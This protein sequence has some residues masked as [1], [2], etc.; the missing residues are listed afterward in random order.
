MNPF[1][2][3]KIIFF[4]YFIMGITTLVFET[5]AIRELTIVFGGTVYSIST[6]LGAFMA[7]SAIGAFYF[8]RIA[9][10]HQKPL[11]LYMFL[12]GGLTV[13]IPLFPLI[14]KITY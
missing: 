13:F 1:M 9:D 2:S 4:L 5:L 10:H 8:G 12:L 7:G 3:R 6:I 14:S 11:M